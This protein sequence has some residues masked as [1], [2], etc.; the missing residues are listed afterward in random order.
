MLEGP[1]SMKL[2]GLCPK[3]VILIWVFV[4]TLLIDCFD[5]V[6]QVGQD[7]MLNSIRFR[8]LQVRLLVTS[9]LTT[10][11]TRGTQVAVCGL[12]WLSILFWTVGCSVFSVPTLV[13]H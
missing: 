4:T 1:Y 7:C 3:G 12:V 5:S 6:L 13:R 2:T 11:I 9:C 8:V 10:F